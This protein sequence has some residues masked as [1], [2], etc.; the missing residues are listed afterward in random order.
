MSAILSAERVSFQFGDEPLLNGIDF[1]VLQKD[2]VA[3]IGSNGAGKSTLLRLIL[4]ELLPQSGRITLFGEDSAHFKN[5]PRLCY[6]PQTNPVSGGAFPA[7]AEE[8]VCASLYAQIGALRPVRRVHRKKALEALEL[9]GMRDFANR[10]ISQLSGGQL[11]RVMLARALVAD[12][13]LLLL[14]EPT[15]GIDSESADR[16]YELLRQLNENGLTIVMVTHDTER[17]A[18]Y[19]SRTFCLE[20]GSIVELAYEQL[21]HELEHK[22]KHKHNPAG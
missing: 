5:W 17:A 13:E 19:V 1:S 15:T 14:D 9:V 2:F 18:A 21:A 8:I 22:H 20:E 10:M 12:C 11:Q 16:L 6:V 4:G 3:I 7:T